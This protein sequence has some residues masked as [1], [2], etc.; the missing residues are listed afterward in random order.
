MG[1]N[2]MLHALDAGFSDLN[3]C[4]L[5][6]PSSPSKREIVAAEMVIDE[7]MRRC[8]V[9]WMQGNNNAGAI[10]I[11]LGTRSSWNGLGSVVSGVAAKAAKLPAE[12]YAI[13]SG[14]E[15]ASAWIAVCGS[16]ERGLI[17]GAG[18]MLRMLRLTRR[19][20][21]ADLKTMNLTSSPH[22]AVRG[23]QLGYRPKTNAYDA[24]TVEM[25]DQY[26]R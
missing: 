18:R 14:G 11:Y 13:S 17:F 7:I 26:I 15:G 8:G 6:V 21:T 23:H 25:W 20:V 4:S 10:K 24:L 5:I 22:Y 19:S 1:R 9:S 12:S 2:S 16:D 3:H